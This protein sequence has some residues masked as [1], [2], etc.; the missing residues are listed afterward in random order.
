MTIT[1]DLNLENI[2]HNY[3]MESDFGYKR[4]CEAFRVQYTRGKRVYL[5]AISN[6]LNASTF[7]KT[8]K[9]EDNGDVT[10]GLGKERIKIGEYSAE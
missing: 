6:G 1:L 3:E 7:Y 5:T 10:I 8:M 9:F 4:N 2:A